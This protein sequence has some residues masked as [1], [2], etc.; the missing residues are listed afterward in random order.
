MLFLL[1]LLIVACLLQFSVLGL[2]GEIRTYFR[3]EVAELARGL[4]FARLI[5]PVIPWLRCILRLFR[6]RQQLLCSYREGYCPP[7]IVFDSP[8]RWVREMR[9][10]EPAKLKIDWSDTKHDDWVLL[11]K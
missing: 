6:A 2:R 7:M 5:E 10:V 8:L 1:T 3:T 11:N 9:S 4:E